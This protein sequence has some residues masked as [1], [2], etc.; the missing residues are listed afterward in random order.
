VHL[1]TWITKMGLMHHY[2]L[3]KCVIKLT[4]LSVLYNVNI[5]CERIPVGLT[6]NKDV[7]LESFVGDGDSDFDL[8]FDFEGVSETAAF[9]VVENVDWANV[10]PF[11]FGIVLVGELKFIGDP[12]GTT[13]SKTLSVGTS[14]RLE[15]DAPVSCGA[16]GPKAEGFGLFTEGESLLILAECFVVVTLCVAS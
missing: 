1:I 14:D 6:E 10:F 8:V 12:G 9:A 4:Q 15:V 7:D 5:F 3:S 16:L 11:T 13:L 2:S